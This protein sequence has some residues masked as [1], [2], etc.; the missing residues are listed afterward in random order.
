[1]RSSRF[2]CTTSELSKSDYSFR[3]KI[4][5]LEFMKQYFLTCIS[6]LYIQ[7][8]QVRLTIVSSLA[9]S[10]RLPRN[11]SFEILHNFSIKRH[12]RENNLTF[13]KKLYKKHDL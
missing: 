5:T 7:R 6:I 4:V 1:M 3:I 11:E 10:L 2:N 13:A 12:M 8:I 9:Q